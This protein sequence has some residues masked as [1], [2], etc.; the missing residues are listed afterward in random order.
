MG[1]LKNSFSYYAIN[2]SH[3]EELPL[4]RKI[5]N[6]ENRGQ[7][8]EVR[9][10]ICTWKGSSAWRKQCNALILAHQQSQLHNWHE[11]QK[12][13]TGDANR[14]ANLKWYQEMLS[15][16]SCTKKLIWPTCHGTRSVYFCMNA[17]MKKYWL[18][19]F[20]EVFA[21]FSMESNTKPKYFTVSQNPVFFFSH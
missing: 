16:C 8:G 11:Q 6:T 14:S 12:P 15:F 20:T 10:T 2:I 21:I 13:D 4:S 18:N 1:S 5:H 7:S 9:K 17:L 3:G 19:S